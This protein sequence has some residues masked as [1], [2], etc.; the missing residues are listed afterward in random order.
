MTSLETIQAMEERKQS[1]GRRAWRIVDRILPPT[2][3]R[4]SAFYDPEAFII[5]RRYKDKRARLFWHTFARLRAKAEGGRPRLDLPADD[6]AIRGSSMWNVAK[7]L[8][9]LS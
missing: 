3:C 8:E 4:P 5:V 2:D 1:Y 6:Y 9:A 7:E